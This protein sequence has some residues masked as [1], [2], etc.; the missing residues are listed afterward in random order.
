MFY[1]EN[2]E[3]MRQI[4]GLS[5][6]D[7]A[8]QIGVSEQAIWQ[9]EAKNV[10]PEINK[11]H[12]L[13]QLFKVKSHFF[14]KQRDAILN[15]AS[16]DIHRIAFRTKNQ[17]SSNKL[18]NRQHKQS[19]FISNFTNYLFS[20]VSQP[21]LKI[22][23]II[24]EIDKVWKGQP[25]NKELINRI[26]EQA[27]RLILGSGT[28]QNLLLEIEKMGIVVYEQ[29]LDMSTDAYSFWSNDETPYII[30]GD[31]KGIAVRRNFDIAHELG[32]LLL[33]RQVEFD[34][35]TRDEYKDVEK[36]ADWFAAHFLLPEK[37]FMEDFKQVSRKSNP[38]YF[39]VLKE[40]WHV[41][42]QAMAMRAYALKGLTDSQYRYF[43]SLINKK[44]FKKIEPLDNTIDLPKPV[45][46]NSLMD[47]LFRKQVL[48]PEQ[49]LED[50]K[51]E[52][53]FFHHVLRIHPKLFYKFMEE[54]KE[55]QQNEIV[56]SLIHI[57]SYH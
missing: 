40:K 30:L 42:I 43:W 23:E 10:M 48:T 50:Y 49:I 44:G 39:V 45:K 2:L 41:S 53:E 4:N 47:L 34:L 51:V 38:E 9:Y 14:L 16:V 52:P 6:S 25:L 32:H 54:Y 56:D 26:D 20:H 33:H 35:L 37:R 17:K 12:Q 28:N 5:R 8:Q 3:Y 31:N 19:E 55:K 29:Q 7:L 1:G 57:H 46:I 21:K 11:I 27:R 24:N 13:C 18:L 36:E 15:Q 22:Y